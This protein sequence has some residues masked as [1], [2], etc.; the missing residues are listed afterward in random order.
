MIVGLD[1]AGDENLILQKDDLVHQ[2]FKIAIDNGVNRTIH[3]GEATS[4]SEVIRAIELCDVQR[5]GHG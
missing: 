5:I 2:A 1:L 3:A 4:A